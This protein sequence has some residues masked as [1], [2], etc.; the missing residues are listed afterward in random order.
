MVKPGV[1]I[2]NAARGGIVDEDALCD[3]LKEGRVA[4]AGLDVYA[5]EPSTRQPAVRV[6]QRRRDPAP[7]RLHR[8]GAGEGRHRRREV[9]AARARRRV[10]AR[11]GQRAGRRRSPRTCGPACRWPRSSAGSSPRWPAASPPA[12]TVEVRGEIAAYDVKVLEL[13]ALKGV[14]AD[15][16]EEPVTYVNAP[17]F[18]QERGVEVEPHDQRRQ[19]D[20]RNLVT[21]R[22]TLADGR[23]ALGLRHPRAARSRR[24]DRR[25]RRLRRR[26][27]RWPSTWR[28]SATTTGRA[29]SASSAASSARPASTSPACRSLVITRGGHALVALTVDSAF[30]VAVLETIVHRDR[31]RLGP[32]GRSRRSLSGRRRCRAAGELITE[33]LEYD[34]GRRRHGVRPRRIH[35]RPSCLPVTVN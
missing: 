22:G 7:R 27:R 32:R 31:C 20:Y 2:V 1:R 12:S 8:R 9:R 34:G 24:E 14:F 30:P 16:V 33:T 10:R 19:P 11:R 25:G 23:S 13:A 26:P 4:G 29:S 21:V 5:K 6:R 3:A 28:S 17:L 15:V 35:Q 18:A